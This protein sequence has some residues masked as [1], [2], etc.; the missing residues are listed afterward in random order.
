MPDPI[1]ASK[2]NSDTQND[3]FLM[4]LVWKETTLFSIFVHRAG[5]RFSDCLTSVASGVT[6]HP[7]QSSRILRRGLTD[8]YRMPAAPR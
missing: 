3:Q 1:P 2:V 6:P 4:I 7:I 5:W 8:P